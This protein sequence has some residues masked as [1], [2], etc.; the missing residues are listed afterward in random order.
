MKEIIAANLIRYRKG[1]GL[2]QEQLATTTGVTRQSI[3][4]YENA[5]TLPDSKTLSALARALSV[6]LDDLLRSETEGLPNF[7]FR[8]YATFGKNPQF[9]AQVLRML[10]TYKA[11]EQ[12]L[13]LPTYTPE[14][15]P[16][17]SVSGNEKRIQ[18]IAALFRHRLGLGDAPIVNLFQ[19]V[20]E[21]GLKVLRQSIPIKGFFG[22]SACSDIEGAFVLVNTPGQTHLIC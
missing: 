6:T 1:L 11:L 16:C 8:A 7:R 19:S 21:I 14:S 13:D 12:A 15:T 9:A 22:L 20:E 3:N 10:Q 5:K 18:A 17:H 2:S 4:N